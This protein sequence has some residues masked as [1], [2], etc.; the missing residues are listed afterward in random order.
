MLRVL[1]EDVDKFTSDVIVSVENVLDTRGIEY[2]ILSILTGVNIDT[3]PVY[4][5]RI[6]LSSNKS[7]TGLKNEFTKSII[8]TL[9]KNG[10]EFVSMDFDKFHD[11]TI[12]IIYFTF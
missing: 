3:T 11:T 7:I 12:I 5:L 6:S 10:R 2:K 4:K 1:K 9:H 8:K